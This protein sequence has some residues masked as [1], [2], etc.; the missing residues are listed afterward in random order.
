MTQTKDPIYGP[1]FRKIRKQN[2]ISLVEACGNITSKSSLARWETGADNLSWKQ[3][4]D[5]LSY[6]HIQFAEFIRKS[7]SPYLDELINQVAVAYNA[8]QTTILKDYATNFLAEYKHKKSKKLLFKTAIACNYYQDLSMIKIYPNNI[9][10]VLQS[11]FQKIIDKN[12]IW[13]YEDIFYFGNTVLLYDPK[14]L[15]NFAFNLIDYIQEHSINVTEWYEFALTM[16]LNAEFALIKK[17]SLYARQLLN[18]INSLHIKDLYSLT[19]IRRKFMKSLLLYT[20]THDD[21]AI[22]KILSY[23]DFLEMYNLKADFNFAFNQIKQIY[24]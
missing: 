22:Y 12:N 24:N 7:V 9:Q 11:Y 15:Y 16:L 23:L 17:K 20:S 13:T 1:K 6:N 18:D 19:N 14:S 8:N 4:I 5:L 21:T 2:H 3:V 10:I